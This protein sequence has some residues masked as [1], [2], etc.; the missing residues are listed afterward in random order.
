MALTATA[1]SKVVDDCTNTLGLA[2]P[3]VYRSSFNRSNLRYSVQLKDSKTNASIASRIAST[4]GSGIIFCITRKDCE[5]VCKDISK[6]LLNNHNCS[7]RIS[8]YHSG[9]SPHEKTIRHR[10]WANGSIQVLCATSAFGMGVDKGN[11]RFVIHHS[12]PASITQ[13]YQESGR[14]GRDG[15]GAE[16]IL[17][18]SFN[19]KDIWKV[20]INSSRGTMMTRES[21]IT[22]LYSCVRYCEDPFVC[23]RTKLLSHFGETFPQSSCGRT[24]DY[25]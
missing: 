23:R 18:Y 17:Y 4:P 1:S 10:E 9:L 16:C 15:D 21:K 11:V 5:K 13:Y 7:K 20:M 8:Y 19:D 2:N 3:L 22:D 24:C 6:I 25:W 14:A 12:L